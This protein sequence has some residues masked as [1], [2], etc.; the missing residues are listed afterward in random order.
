MRSKTLKR[1]LILIGAV[2]IFTVSVIFVQRYQVGRLARTKAQEADSAVKEGDFQKAA[3]LY[4]EHL[5]VVPDD[6]EIQI[7]Y[8]D[9]LLKES[10]SPQRQATALKL[11]GEVLRHFPGR[12]DVR[13]R[14]MELKFT[15]G[16]FSDAGAEKDLGMLLSLPQNKTDGNLHFMMGRCREEGKNDLEAKDSYEKAIKADGP[17]KIEASQRLASLLRRPDRLNDPKA[18]DQVVDEMVQASPDNYQ[19]YLVSAGVIVA[20]MGCPMPERTSRRRS[21]WPATSPSSCWRWPGRRRPSRRRRARKILEAGLAKIPG[22]TELYQSLADL[23]LH[24]GHIDK[25]IATLERGLEISGQP[26]RP[27]GGD[28]QLHG[29]ARRHRQA[30][31]ANR[32]AEKT[33]L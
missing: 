15:M 5:S 31:A 19:V 1:W 6:V 13:R 26:G 20:S 29:H 18:A 4:S 10:P 9:T 12:E 27:P 21:S 25:A 30:L 22:S 7:K 28:C 8:A 24:T 33:G 3:K 17:R 2:S 14:Q 16:Q 23:E 11:Y 32:G